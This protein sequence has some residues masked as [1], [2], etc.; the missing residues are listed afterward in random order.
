MHSVGLGA[1][2]TT[3]K[4]HFT[5]TTKYLISLTAVCMTLLTMIIRVQIYL[6]HMLL[7]NLNSKSLWDIIHHTFAISSNFHQAQKEKALNR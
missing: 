1:I 5:L 4:F 6:L 3:G 2:L 7:G